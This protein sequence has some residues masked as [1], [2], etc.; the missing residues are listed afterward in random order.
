MIMGL[1]KMPNPTAVQLV[2]V[3]Q[4]MPLRPLTVVGIDSSAHARP[5]FWLAIIESHPVT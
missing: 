3:G 5:A 1:P 2:V 4:E